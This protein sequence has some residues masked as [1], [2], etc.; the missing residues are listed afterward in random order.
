MLSPCCFNVGLGLVLL[1]NPA[2]FI[3]LD[4]IMNT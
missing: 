3:D 1:G 4:I 2:H